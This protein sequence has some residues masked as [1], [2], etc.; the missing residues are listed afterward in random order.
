MQ[1][2]TEALTKSEIRRYI[3]VLTADL[4]QAFSDTLVRIQDQSPRRKRLALRAL[5]WVSS[6]Y[7]PLSAQELCHALATEVGHLEFDED[8]LL[9]PKVIVE[10]CLGLINIDQGTTQVRLVHLALKD[11]LKRV[12]L[13]SESTMDNETYMTST[14]LTYLCFGEDCASRYGIPAIEAG[15]GLSPSFYAYAT[16]NWGHHAKMASATAIK[17]QALAYL[18]RKSANARDF[19]HSD[20]TPEAV[21]VFCQP[22]GFLAPLSLTG[23]HIAAGFGLSELVVDLLELE[24]D[25]NT[26]D[27]HDNT[28][29]HIAATNGQLMAAV[30][31]LRANANPNSF[32]L[33]GRT[34][35]Y[36]AVSLSHAPLVIA[37]LDHGAAVDA[38]CED[39]WSPLHKAAD[40]GDLEITR[41]LISRGASVLSKSARALIPLHRAAGHGH[42]EIVKELLQGGSPVDSTTVD[43]WT[44]LHGACNSGQA[45]AA[46]LLIAN[47]AKVDWKSNDG[48]SPLHRACRGSH[49]NAVELLLKHRADVLVEDDQ[50]DIALHRAAK[51]DCLA[52]CDLLLD[53]DE[54]S[55]SSQLKTLNNEKRTPREEAMYQGHQHVADVLKDHELRNGIISGEPLNILELAITRHY[56]LSEFKL[57]L[58]EAAQNDP[59]T[60]RNL[61]L[62]HCALLS[63][64]EAIAEY[65]IDLPM[66][67]LTSKTE[68]GWQPLH[69]AA[70]SSNNTFVQLCLA[71][72][73]PID[74]TTHDGQTPLHKACK[75]GDLSSVNLLLDAGAAIDI[76]DWWGWTP[77][78][79]ASFAGSQAVVESLLDRGAQLHRRDKK[80]RTPHACAAEAGNHALCQFFRQQRMPEWDFLKA[81][82][83]REV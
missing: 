76:Q 61:K 44:P 57:L 3:N 66:T 14:L 11:Y 18:Q 53:N 73:A 59:T 62:L 37:L 1:G 25:I 19:A 83:L 5:I 46:N 39:N 60:L 13:K 69:C 23:L 79:T 47:Y 21:F 56:D 28:A 49:H 42:L 9:N 77:L 15:R 78:H 41:L 52:I 81:A 17:K 7:R 20:D 4:G 71:H 64:N 55:S 67:D 6:T 26:V 58:G 24:T 70:N 36:D 72:N 29:V 43:G 2:I 22:G 48:R 50:G 8:A 40:I 63:K 65:L 68:D 12:D 27:S 45:E 38:K 54:A 10:S 51:A 74:A 80:G 32:N 31:L 82:Q 30:L 75:T 33:S 16:W 34:P 35:L